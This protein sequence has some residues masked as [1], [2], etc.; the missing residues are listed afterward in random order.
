MDFKLSAEQQDVQKLAIQ[1]FADQT[2]NEHLRQFDGKG[3]Y[4]ANLWSDLSSTGI[5]G[6]A[7][8]DAHGGLG[9]GFETLCLVLEE[10]GRTMA[11]IPLIPVLV[12]A[13]MPL[14]R[15]G[16]EQQKKILSRVVTGNT[17]ISTAFAEP[18]ND[19]P[20]T[21]TT[22][23]EK[24]AGGWQ[25]NG[26]KHC[27]P[28]GSQAEKV[29]ISAQ[30]DQGLIALWLSP[31]S[32]GVELAEQ[33]STS[34]EAQ[35]Q[36]I[37]NNVLVNDADIM[38]TGS[39]AEVIMTY[40]LQ[41]TQAALCAFSVGITDRMV[42]LT[43]EYTTEREQFDVKIATF[44]AVA[45]RA[46]DAYIDVECLRLASAEAISLLDQEKPADDAVKIAKIWCGDV[47]HRISQASQHLH[48]GIGV[49]RDYPLFRY[50][51]WSKQVELTLGGSARLLSELGES[52]A[53]EF[54]NR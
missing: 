42:K 52:I 24:V 5:L 7:I 21:P 1:I 34:G 28:Y 36:I 37:L 49:D 12:S 2:D 50:A 48:G 45:H 15:F 16:P 39:D 30:S 19:D 44:Q 10:A 47:T 3:T 23:A 22:T 32:E 51:L 31:D 4:D 9:F 20:L 53:E 25:L 6:V 33:Q 40:A 43:A 29:L 11:P 46:A 14:Q 35:S 41:R 17:L 8:D 27:V 18:L 38:A 26:I 13:A 54:S